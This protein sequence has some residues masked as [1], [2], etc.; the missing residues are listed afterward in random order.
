MILR[1]DRTRRS[2]GAGACCLENLGLRGRP[3]LG[4]GRQAA[5]LQRRASA[6]HLG[7]NKA[8]T[9]TCTNLVLE[10]SG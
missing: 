1:F 2:R 8:T 10:T 9:D 6:V 3:N 5:R 4:A 7:L